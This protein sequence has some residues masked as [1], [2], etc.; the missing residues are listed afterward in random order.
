MNTTQRINNKAVK[1]LDRLQS[2]K[3]I[4]E[5]IHMNLNM[6]HGAGSTLTHEGFKRVQEHNEELTK[7]LLAYF[8]CNSI[9]YKVTNQI[10]F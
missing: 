7:E 6:I 9:E 8:D 4:E 3:E 5:E 10:P 1:A 2:F